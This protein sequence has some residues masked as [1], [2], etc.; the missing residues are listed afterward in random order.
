MAANYQLFDTSEDANAWLQA[1]LGLGV[2]AA[3]S[4]WEI[5]KHR[6]HLQVAK[7]H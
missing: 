6:R 5:V 4:V 2:V 7:A 1:T 3:F